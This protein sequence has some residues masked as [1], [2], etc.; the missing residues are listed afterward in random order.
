MHKAKTM[1]ERLGKHI[2]EC[3]SSEHW[4]STS[5]DLNPLDYKL[6]SVLLRMVCTRHHH[7]LKSLKQVLVEDVD[8]FHMDFIHTAID[9]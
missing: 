4:L 9:A 8:N 6:W 1:Q 2:P 3:I 7:Y 5:P